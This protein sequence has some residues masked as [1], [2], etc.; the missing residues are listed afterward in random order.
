MAARKEIPGLACHLL[1]Q[2]P[3]LRA[4]CLSL[5]CHPRRERS[6]RHWE[7]SGVGPLA[8]PCTPTPALLCQAFLGVGWLL[9]LGCPVREGACGEWL[10]LGPG[11][12]PA[13]MRNAHGKSDTKT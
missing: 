9:L 4:T 3:W 1:A 11:S 5:D 10:S 12:I 13:E 8:I 7:T 2:A 6:L